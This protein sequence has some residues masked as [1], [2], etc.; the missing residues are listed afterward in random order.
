MSIRRRHTF[1][2][3]FDDPDAIEKFDFSQENASVS[4]SHFTSP[5]EDKITIP[6]DLIASYPKV[7]II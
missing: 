1:F 7:C 5:R 6:Y 4:S 3:Q 2:I